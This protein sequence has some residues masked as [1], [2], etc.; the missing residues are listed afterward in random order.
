MAIKR[1][2]IE[3]V[4]T[5]IGPVEIA[6]RLRERVPQASSA[7]SDTLNFY[8]IRLYEAAPDDCAR[9]AQELTDA[10]ETVL[11]VSQDSAG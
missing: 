10:G 9:L 8:G 3:L 11:L 1:S 7:K 5:T 2:L 6:E 4:A